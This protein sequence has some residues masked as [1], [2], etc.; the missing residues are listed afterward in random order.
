MISKKD[1]NINNKTGVR[2]V[3]YITSRH[4]YKAYLSYNKKF[5]HLG[6]YDNINDAIKARKKAEDEYFKTI[7][8][9]YKK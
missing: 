6:Y 1:A 4:K 9:T 8:N 7:L 3:C 2:G 5:Y